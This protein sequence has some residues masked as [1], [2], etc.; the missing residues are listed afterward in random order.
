MWYSWS[1]CLK[2]SKLM[3]YQWKTDDFVRNVDHF[4]TEKLVEVIVVQS[5]TYHIAR[6]IA[7]F[8]A[9]HMCV[10]VRLPAIFLF[11]FLYCVYATSLPS[12]QPF[13]YRYII[14]IITFGCCCL[15]VCILFYGNFVRWSE[16]CL[17]R[18]IYI[19]LLSYL[20]AIRI[21]SV[22][23]SLF[24]ILN[25]SHAGDFCECKRHAAVP[26]SVHSAQNTPL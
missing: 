24:I 25:F 10:C 14:I 13:V 6:Q 15:F 17:H 3:E 19:S 9:P 18:Y 21:D 26:S 7:K 8:F 20:V 12:L 4:Y 11:L 2:L 16:K 23:V 22:S 5:T 1:H